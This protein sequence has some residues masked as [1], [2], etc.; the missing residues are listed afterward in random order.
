M[1]ADC[2]FVQGLTQLLLQGIKWNKISFFDE[3]ACIIFKIFISLT[4]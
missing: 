4:F 2:K 3:E 1:T